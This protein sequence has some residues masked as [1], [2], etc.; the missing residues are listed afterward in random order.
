MTCSF[1][2]VVPLANEAKT[3]QSF[4]GKIQEVLNSLGAGKVYLVVD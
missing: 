3:F 1:A 4:I 2:L